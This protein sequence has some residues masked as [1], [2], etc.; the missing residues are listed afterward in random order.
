LAEKTRRKKKGV[1]MD[2][3]IHEACKLGE[4]IAHC[5]IDVI[6]KA[7]FWMEEKYRQGS[8]DKIAA[9][10]A[11]HYLMLAMRREYQTEPGT[12]QEH[13]AHALHWWKAASQDHRW[14]AAGIEANE[15]SKRD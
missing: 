3:L 10:I 13:I 9:M 2:S 6:L 4:Q 15:S 5:R 14:N 11:L 7:T 8:S 12:V 1:T